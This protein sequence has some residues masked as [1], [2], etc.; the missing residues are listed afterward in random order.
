MVTWLVKG[1][2]PSGVYNDNNQVYVLI[3]KRKHAKDPF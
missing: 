3:T 1:Y 2:T